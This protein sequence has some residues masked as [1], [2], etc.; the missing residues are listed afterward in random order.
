LHVL[1]NLRVRRHN[2][3]LSLTIRRQIP[4]THLGVPPEKNTARGGKH[5]QAIGRLSPLVDFRL[6]QSN[7]ELALDGR[8]LRI[9][10]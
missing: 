9:V 4:M 7:A 1:K 10:E 6:R 3:S 8:Q 2:A 5:V